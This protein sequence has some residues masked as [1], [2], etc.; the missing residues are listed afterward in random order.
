M[1]RSASFYAAAILRGIGFS[2][3]AGAPSGGT[4]PSPALVRNASR[5]VLVL[6]TAGLLI[7]QKAALYHVIASSRNFYGVLS[8][9]SED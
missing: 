1:P 6:L 5:V 9:V 4:S 3:C 7:P 2:V 8:V